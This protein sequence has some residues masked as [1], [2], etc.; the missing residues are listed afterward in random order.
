MKVYF[1]GAEVAQATPSSTGI[2]T[3]AVGPWIGNSSNI[4]SGNNQFNGDIDEV[5]IWNRALQLD[6]IQRIYNATNDNP[7][8]TANLWSAGLNTGLVYWNRMGD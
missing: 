3:E 8:K 7:G 6:D 1:D 4:S 5:A 2:N